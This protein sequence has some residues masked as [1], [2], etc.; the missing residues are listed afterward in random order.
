MK[1]PIFTFLTGLLLLV[2]ATGSLCQD[3]ANITYRFEADTV[4]V[5]KGQTIINRLVVTNNSADSAVI[6]KTTYSKTQH[7]LELPDEI[8]MAPGAELGFPV[9]IMM[10]PASLREL[11]YRYEVSYK[12]ERQIN[13]NNYASFYLQSAQSSTQLKISAPEQYVFINARNSIAPVMIKCTN[14][15]FSHE[16]VEI[17][18]TAYP[19]GLEFTEPIRYFT[20]KAGE[21]EIITFHPI[22]ASRSKYSP[23]YMVNFTA[24]TEAGEL[25]GTALVK[26]VTLSDKK[27]FDNPGTVYYDY[28]KHFADITAVSA[29]NDLF[30]Y[31]M[32]AGGLKQF[33]DSS[34][35]KYNITANKYNNFRYTADF[36]DTWAE[37]DNKYGSIR[38]GNIYETLDYVIYG[39]GVKATVN[40]S[41]Q[42]QIGLYYVNNNYILYS[43]NP[44]TPQQPNVYVAT[45]KH[46]QETGISNNGAIIH[47]KDQR[48]QK[49]TTLITDRVTHR[50]DKNTVLGIGAGYSRETVNLTNYQSNDGYMGE[51]SLFKRKNQW[52]IMLSNYYSS[53]YFAGIRRGTAQLEERVSYALTRK[54]SVYG[55][56][57]R[58]GYNPK[59]PQDDNYFR[60][61]F[62]TSNIY[63]GGI[64]TR[65]KNHSVQSKVYVM[66][67]IFREYITSGTANTVATS[68][69]KRLATEVKTDYESDHFMLSADVGHTNYNRAGTKQNFIS[70]RFTGAYSHDFL[71][72]SMVYQRGPFYLTDAISQAPGQYE[73]FSIGPIVNL[74]DFDHKIDASFAGYINYNRYLS[75]WNLVTST[76]VNYKPGKTWLLHGQ[77]L[78]SRVFQTNVYS[79]RVGITKEFRTRKTIG[80]L[81]KLR[82]FGDR[83]ANGYKDEREAYLRGMT[84]DMNG[85][86]AYTNDKGMVTYKHVPRGEQT[87][88]LLNGKG[89]YMQ[90]PMISDEAERKQ[91]ID[92]PLVR[93][94][95]LKG[96]VKVM[97]NKYDTKP[98]NPEGIKVIIRDTLN[99]EYKTYLDAFGTFSIS[100]P[101]N[102]Y[103][104]DVEQVLEQFKVTNPGQK[105]DIKENENTELEFEL[106]DNNRTIDIKKF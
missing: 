63:E 51:L 103:T 79:T 45:L 29:T 2:A 16:N 82:A 9:K 56:Y 67:Q 35:L 78:Y 30:F 34:T 26:V 72:V 71:G 55:R 97:K 99:N 106:I 5:N 98:F 85:N 92:I 33:N 58:L 17:R 102:S 18:A 54:L 90:G 69:S 62:N 31:Q 105:A 60:T 22:D 47:A 91:I 37:Y 14:N 46:G 10:T 25:I 6:I 80:G 64:N 61:H 94:G 7:L 15:G 87:I 57:N 86:V 48:A 44:N 93:S 11:K 75:G 27:Q 84:L 1:K 73:Y 23:D 24:F 3:V 42:D 68:L 20:V 101:V 36:F 8:R 13:L 81:V 41:P 19:A 74:K 49:E 100:L 77:L 21:S 89:W 50:I 43:D 88:R 83:N 40:V 96:K 39:R 32:R 28:D 65:Y 70:A 66:E 53:P 52:D 4:I 95:I 104:V 59:F 76:T 12:T 38:A